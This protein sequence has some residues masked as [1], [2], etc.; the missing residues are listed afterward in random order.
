MP[1]F[2]I[3]DEIVPSQKNSGAQPKIENGWPDAPIAP[4]NAS[5]LERLTYPAGLAG[6]AV[7]YMVDTAR[8][9]DRWMALGTVMSVL[10]KGIDR[11]VIG[12]TGC[13][14]VG[15]DAVLAWTGA[16]KQHKLNCGQIL[17]GAMGVQ[18]CYRAGGIASIQ[19]IEQLIEGTGQ[20][21]NE[22]PPCPNSLIIID[23]FGSWLSRITSKSQTG[24]VNE[25]PSLLNTLWGW[26]PENIPWKSSIKV[27]KNVKGIYSPAFSILGFS[28]EE[29]F[30]G[31][32]KRSDA[33]LS[34]G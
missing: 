23:E 9:P 1:K 17:L 25:I 29:K 21:Y 6:H 15:Y 4:D 13:S 20:G 30:F 2:D 3:L 24:N 34:I 19:S 18:D 14:N 5:D 10:G 26:A 32:L 11:K 22:V 16:G 8:L 28:T 7:Q 27:G 31:S 33:S 12:P